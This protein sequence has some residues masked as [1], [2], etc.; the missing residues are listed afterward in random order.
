[1]QLLASL[2]SAAISRAMQLDSAGNIYLAGTVTIPNPQPPQNTTDV[3][4]AKV[5]ADGSKVL[6]YTSFGGSFAESPAGLVLGSDGSAYLAGST[7]SSD[8]PVTAG[9]YQSTMNPR[10][11][12][13]G[14]LVKV[15]PA[16]ATSTERPSPPSQ[17][18]R[19][20]RAARSTSPDPEVRHTR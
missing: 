12:S 11:A 8:F 1:V 6:Y 5:S 2:P 19:S 7:E 14:F 13:Q 10:G 3:F 9:A 17:E 20:T 18:L 16:P 4:I 15:S